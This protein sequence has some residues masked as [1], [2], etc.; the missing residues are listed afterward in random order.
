MLQPATTPTSSS[1]GQAATPTTPAA[2]TTPQVTTGAFLIAGNT[3]GGA[4]SLDATGVDARFFY[5]AAIATNTAGNLYVVDSQGTIRK[6]TAAGVVTTVPG[7]AGT[8][9]D[10]GNSAVP[11]YDIPFAPGNIAADAAGNV[12]RVGNGTIRKITPAGVVTTLA[13]TAGVRGN[14]DGSGSAAQFN[15]PGS[16]TADT[17]GNLYVAD[18]GNPGYGA[19][20][21]KIT[22]TG[23]VTTLAGTPGVNGS[24]D[25]S[26]AAAQFNDPSGIAVDV[27]GNL[28]VVDPGN[29]NIR[30]ITPAGV[31]TTLA[32][33]TGV[34]F[35]GRT[36]GSGASRFGYPHYIAVDA[37]GNVYVT[38]TVG[39]IVRKITPTGVVTTLAG[40]RGVNGSADGSG[41]AARFNYPQGI[42][43]DMA[44]NLVVA[45]TRNQII[46]KITL[47]GEVTTLAGTAFATGSANGGG[48]AAQFNG[49]RG[50][51]AD[52]AGNLYVADRGNGTI[53]KITP[54][55]V[56][57]T[58]AGT[59]GVFGSADGSGA[60]AQF[61][62]MDGIAADTAGN[63]YV[64]DSGVSNFT[65]GIGGTIRKISPSGVVTTLAGTPGVFG[66]ADGSGAAAQFGRPSGIAVD[67]A[68]SLYVTDTNNDTIRKITAAGVVTTLAGTPGVTGHTDGSGAAAQFTRPNGT[69][70]DMAGN[71]Y[72]IDSSNAIRKI[73]AG[74]VVTTLAGTPALSYSERGIGSVDGSGAAARF[75]YPQ[76]IAVDAGGN[77]YVADTDNHT[78]RKIT[79][80]G[81]VTTVAGVAGQ[82]GILLGSLPGSL[83]SPQGVALLANN[84]LAVTTANSVLKLMLP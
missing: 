15:F 6:I 80:A 52:S 34:A 72:V 27:A 5:P 75:N 78:I 9:Y 47:A 65:G 66:R 2:N 49:P 71:L 83:S 63:L 41:A 18:S 84:T 19:T 81:V 12:Y 14:L 64:A 31:V 24:A 26:G 59:P 55:G 69:A 38:D 20:I 74:G 43:L 32:G 25:G 36:D 17:A 16:I 82:V 58:L 4:D 13:G 57:T 40:T 79:P 76:G 54:A 70:V 10:F 77:L 28:Y 46:R 35:T 1:T 23:V 61:F 56:V 8:R 21:R 48:A 50:I 37:A 22:P 60:A 62:G 68:G 39:Q 29:Q 67:T 3:G 33:T 51:T 11:P 44:G 73:T 7:T 45:D 30:K 53:R 42:A